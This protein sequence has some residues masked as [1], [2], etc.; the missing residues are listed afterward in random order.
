[1]F[2]LFILD[3]WDARGVCA[4]SA[5]C[6]LINSSS[7]LPIT[8]KATHSGGLSGKYITGTCVPVKLLLVSQVSHRKTSEPKVSFDETENILVLTLMRPQRVQMDSPFSQAH[9]LSSYLQHPAHL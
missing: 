7:Y 9:K 6:W 5:G 2:R 1:M 4:G 8:S 3:N